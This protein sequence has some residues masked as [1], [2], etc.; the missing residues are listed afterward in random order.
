LNKGKLE[1]SVRGDAGNRDL[2]YSLPNNYVPG[3]WLPGI[4][5]TLSDKPMILQVDSYF[6][7]GSVQ[8]TSL[9][10]IIIRPPTSTARPTTGADGST[11]LHAVSLEINGSG[12]RS[13]WYFR[14][15]GTLDGIDEADSIHTTRQELSN[16]EMDFSRDPQMK[17]Q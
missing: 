1:L 5:A 2:T 14:S 12:E 9:L 4:L 11:S 16:L 8:N 7:A 15:D 13:T 17:P 10:T 3:G 6:D